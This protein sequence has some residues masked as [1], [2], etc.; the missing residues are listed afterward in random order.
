MILN[1]PLEDAATDGVMEHR[2]DPVLGIGYL[3]GP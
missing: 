1:L 2:L 3:E